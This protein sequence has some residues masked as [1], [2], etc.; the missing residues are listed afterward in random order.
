MV[1]T[2]LIVIVADT[3]ITLKHP[4]FSVDAIVGSVSMLV[5]LDRNGLVEVLATMSS[6]LTLPLAIWF[7][8]T[9]ER[10]IT[11]LQY[12]HNDIGGRRLTCRHP[13]DVIVHHD[14]LITA[15]SHQRRAY[16][17]MASFTFCMSPSLLIN[18]T[19][20][21]IELLGYSLR[22]DDDGSFCRGW[23]GIDICVCSAYPGIRESLKRICHVTIL[24]VANASELSVKP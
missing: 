4:A 12:R 5:A 16:G 24:T 21:V 7:V 23:A 1:N 13:Q 8:S 17:T 18:C 22:S 19:D 11:D 20:T 9:V 6:F 10:A 14:L 3:V 15:D 2:P